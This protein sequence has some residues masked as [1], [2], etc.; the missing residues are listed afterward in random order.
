M[1]RKRF[2][3]AAA[4]VATAM[5]AT[6]LAAAAAPA[7]T[8]QPGVPLPIPSPTGRNHWRRNQSHSDRNI[9]RVRKHLDLVIDE[10]QHDQHDYGGHRETALDLLHQ[11]REQLL[12]AEQYD[13]Q[14]PDNG[15]TARP[16]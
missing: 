6:G 5:V 1:E 9:S 8:P 14:H 13:A 16:L 11:A 10:L 12:D 15:P 7:V 4:G 2:L 3:T